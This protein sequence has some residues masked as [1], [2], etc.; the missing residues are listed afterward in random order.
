LEFIRHRARVSGQPPDYGN[1]DLLQRARAAYLEPGG[2]DIE[3]SIVNRR[4]YANHED[5]LIQT[6]SVDSWQL[7]E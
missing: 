5:M 4:I 6:T 3:P 2:I 7:D 1:A